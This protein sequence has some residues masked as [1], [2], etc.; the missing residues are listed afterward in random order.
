MNLIE[1]NLFTFC[2]SKYGYGTSQV[3]I[4]NVCTITALL[5]KL[6]SS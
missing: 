2:K 1:L 3:Q 6:N 4:H 5:E